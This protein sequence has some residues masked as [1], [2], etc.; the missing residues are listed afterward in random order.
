MGVERANMVID[1]LHG[2]RGFVRFGFLVVLVR[3]VY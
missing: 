2:G 3:R 1:V